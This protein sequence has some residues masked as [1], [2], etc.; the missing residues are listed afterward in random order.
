MQTMQDVIV[1]IGSFI[2]SKLMLLSLW[3]FKKIQLSLFLVLST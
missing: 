3:C 2:I 1:W